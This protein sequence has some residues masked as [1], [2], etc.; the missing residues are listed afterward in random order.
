LEAHVRAAQRRGQLSTEVDPRQLAFEL[1]AFPLLA[2]SRY[3]L[4]GDPTAF[5]LAQAAI[6]RTIESAKPAGA[7]N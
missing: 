2:N 5:D 3:Q 4:T 6:R 1:D 7:P